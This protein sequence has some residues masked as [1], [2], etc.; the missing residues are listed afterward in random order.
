MDVL[1]L[2]A[3]GE[4]SVE[5]RLVVA[6]NVTLLGEVTHGDQ[7]VRCVYKPVAGERPLWDFPDGTLAARE[8]AAYLVSEATGWHV[9]PPTAMRT[10]G[11]LGP[12]MCQLWVEQ[13]QQP[14]AWVD[15]VAPDEVP[16]AALPILE[17]V[18]GD[19]EPVVLVHAADAGLRRL[20][21]F[22]VVVNNADRKGGHVLAG[23]ADLHPEMADIVG[24]DHGV[25]FHLEP[26]L[27]T[28]L[29]G[30]AGQPLRADERDDLQRLGTRL[31]GET[32]EQLAELLA[33]P[34][35]AAIDARIA[36]LLQVNRF[37]EPEGRMPVPWPVF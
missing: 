5:G 21:L 33:E 23:D 35:L 24:V 17:A 22:D 14:P 16:T 32:G 34:E 3:R 9:V 7:R 10:D 29:W 20:A 1:G 37:P 4:L 36:T 15:V 6:S 19:G 26:K 2:L 18:D 25:T 13:P 31:A 28:V 12:G 8:V 30:W 27:R 11:P